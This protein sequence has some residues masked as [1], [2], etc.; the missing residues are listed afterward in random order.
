MTIPPPTEFVTASDVA[1]YVVCPEAF[2]LKNEGYRKRIPSPTSDEAQ[3]SRAAWVESNE[4]SAKLRRYTIYVYGLVVLIVLAVFA[5]E[6]QL[7]SKFKLERSSRV[8]PVNPSGQSWTWDQLTIDPVVPA[9]LLMIILLLG[10]LIFVWDLLDRRSRK[11]KKSAGLT[12][13]SRVVGLRGSSTLASQELRSDTLALSARPHGMIQETDS[14][15]PIEVFPTAKKVQDR[16]VAQLLV[17][18]RLV[19]EAQGAAPPY[20]ILLIG[21]ERRSI[22][23]RYSDEKKRWLDDILRNMREILAGA[24]ATP[25]PSFYKCRSCDLHEICQH[26]LFRAKQPDEAPDPALDDESNE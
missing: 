13:K 19:E 10:V 21:K 12:E 7:A 24:P 18:L 6:R 11:L 4:L 23:L 20:G 25:L 5:S 3:R 22:Q 15:I 1:T 14:L 8:A 2:R 9:E 17:A 16:H 26:S